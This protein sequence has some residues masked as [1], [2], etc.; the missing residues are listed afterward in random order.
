MRGPNR[1]EPVTGPLAPYA[2]GFQQLL[3]AHGYSPSAVRL[4]LWLFDHVSRWLEQ[5]QLTPHELNAGRAEQFTIARRAKGYRTWVSPHSMVLVLECL[6]AM[7]VVPPAPDAAMNPIEE[8]VEAYRGYLVAERGLA[9]CTVKYYGD[10]ARLFFSV[11]S[12]PDGLDLELLNA[13]HVTGFVGRECARRDTAAAKYLVAGLRSVLRYLYVTG[14][15]TMDLSAAVP[16]VAARRG[17]SLPRG[18]EA[19]QTACLLASCD[20]SR[21][22]GLRDF[23]ILTILLRLGLRCAEVA[24]LRLDAVDWC[25]GEIVIRGKGNVHERMPLPIDVGQALVSY[26]RDGRPAEP[27]RSVFL[28]VRAPRVGLAPCGVGAVV[29]DACVRAGLS[30]VGAH[31]LRHTAGTDLLRAGASLPEVAQVLRHRALG[32]TALYAK[33]DQAALREL[34]EPW[35]GS[36]S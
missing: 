20:R 30:P 10:V 17:A 7:E 27:H 35:P 1:V 2:A 31:R 32:S 14:R 26:L 12:Q 28:R 9:A 34:V 18:L 5:E 15:T 29:H 19:D 3:V 22:V 13:A 21:S 24:A 11:R 8:L 16:G 36:V 4:R 33:V 6:R 23:A 25:R